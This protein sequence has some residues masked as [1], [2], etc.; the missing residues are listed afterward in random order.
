MIIIIITQLLILLIIIIMIV[1][2][3]IIMIGLSQFQTRHRDV[4][5]DTFRGHPPICITHSI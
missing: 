3:I 4:V 5:L 1:I 2:I